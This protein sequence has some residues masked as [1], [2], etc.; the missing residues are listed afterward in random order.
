MKTLGT[1]VLAALLLGLPR[2]SPSALSPDPTFH[3]LLYS[4]LLSLCNRH[5]TAGP[6][7]WINSGVSLITG[8]ANSCVGSDE[9][10][11]L[12]IDI[13]ALLNFDCV[14]YDDGHGNPTRT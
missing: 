11:H 4:R 5:I 6:S 8:V 7:G 9:K 1:R 2:H 12:L 14:G 3:G 13:P 10:V